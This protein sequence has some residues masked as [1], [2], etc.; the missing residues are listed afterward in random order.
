MGILYHI[1]LLQHSYHSC[2]TIC[3]SHMKRLC[4]RLHQ[5]RATVKA[6]YVST[7]HLLNMENQAAE[8]IYLRTICLNEIDA[9]VVAL[10]CVNIHDRHF[11]K[12]RLDSFAQL[13]D[14][15]LIDV[16]EHIVGPTPV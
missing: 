4:P 10:S 2:D 8:N 11:H 6:N 14:L 15:F 5:V 3:V 16:A 1:F 9:G 13:Y 7:V 12:A